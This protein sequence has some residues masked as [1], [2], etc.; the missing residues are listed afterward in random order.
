[1]KKSKNTMRLGRTIVAERERTESESERMI[2]R[3]KAK[4]KKALMTVISLVILAVAVGLIV[5]TV[6][7]IIEQNRDVT[8]KTEEKKYVPSVT[9]EDVGNAGITERMKEYV[10]KV[11]QDFYAYGYKVARAVVP[12]GKAR[13]IDVY[14]DGREEYYK[15][16]IDRGSAVS[17]EDAVRMI[18]YLDEHDIHPEYVDVRIEERAYYK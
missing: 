13:E 18:K 14:L 1:M 5:I 11:E 9:I 12:A 2:A 10:G 8:V 16:N 15:L 6:Y 17:A 4:S 3:K 7:K